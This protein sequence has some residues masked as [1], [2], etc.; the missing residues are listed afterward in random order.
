MLC[1]FTLVSYPPS[2][3]KCVLEPNLPCPLEVV[4]RSIW[5]R[6]YWIFH[7]FSKHWLQPDCITVNESNFYT[8]LKSLLFHHQ[9]PSKNSRVTTGLIIYFH[10]NLQPQS[11]LFYSCFNLRLVLQSI[12]Q[13]IVDSKEQNK[14]KRGKLK[15]IHKSLVMKV[16]PHHVGKMRCSHYPSHW[17]STA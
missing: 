14:D 13:S 2:A 4:Y 8:Y 15:I 10:Q 3:H 5:R 16:T 1:G 17:S 7:A 12:S 6:W 11:K 9:Q